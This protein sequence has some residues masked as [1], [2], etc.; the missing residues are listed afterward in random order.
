MFENIILIGLFII[1]F[2]IVIPVLTY[3]HYEYVVKED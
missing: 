1:V 2:G 3:I